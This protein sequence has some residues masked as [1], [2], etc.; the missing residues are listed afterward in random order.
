M[1]GFI[2]TYLS[3]M[4]YGWIFFFILEHASI[5][6]IQCLEKDLKRLGRGYTNFEHFRNRF[7][8]ATRNNPVFDGTADSDQVQYFD[9]DD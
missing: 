2:T 7:L 8:F 9:E 1:R 5:C 6:M 4:H 3:Q